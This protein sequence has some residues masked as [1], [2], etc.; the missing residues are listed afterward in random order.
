MLKRRTK[1]WFNAVMFIVVIVALAIVA[2][3][4]LPQLKTF[5]TNMK[6][7]QLLA[8]VN[9][10]NPIP[11]KMWGLTV[12][13]KDV[14]IWAL[15]DPSF[16][17]DEMDVTYNSDDAGDLDNAATNGD[18][19]MTV[20]VD[21]SKVKQTNSSGDVVDVDTADFKVWD[22]SDWDADNIEGLFET[23]RKN[24][25][26]LTI[27]KIY[28]SWTKKMTDTEAGDYIIKVWTAKFTNNKDSDNPVDHDYDD[29]YTLK[30]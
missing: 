12:A 7:T 3:V 21:K 8:V 30:Y 19:I 26:T 18:P 14:A 22:T 11:T 28:I 25:N 2:S 15:T 16:S 24:D 9:Q 5:R 23:N 13:T 27:K 17:W 4:A 20:A 29:N 6:A 1:K 10:N